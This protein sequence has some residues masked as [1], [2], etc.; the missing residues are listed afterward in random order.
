MFISDQIITA[1]FNNI[2]PIESDDGKAA[3]E[4]TSGIRYFLAVA[5]IL[6]QNDLEQIDVSPNNNDNRTAFIEAVGRVVKL[7][8]T[9]YTKNFHN[10][11]DNADD[12]RVRNNF[13][14][15]LRNKPYPR[16][17]A[18]LIIIQNDAVLSLHED[19]ETNLLRYGKWNDYK[20]SLAVWLIRFDN[21]PKKTVANHEKLIVAIH[22]KLKDRYGNKVADVL[23]DEA[24]LK[25]FISSFAVPLYKDAKPDYAQISLPITSEYGQNIILYGAPGTGKSYE[26]K[27]LR[28]QIRTV[29]HPDY[30]NSDFIGSY[31]PYVGDGKITYKFVPGPFIKVFVN[32]MLKPDTPYYLIIEEINRAN[33]S[34]VFGEVFQL[35]DRNTEGES[36]YRIVVD[37]SVNDFLKEKLSDKWQGELFIPANFSIYATMNSADQGVSY[38]DTAF[39]RRW[40]FRY[41]PIDFTTIDDDDIRNQKLIDYNGEKYSWRTLAVSINT[42]LT[43]E[44]IQEDRLLGQ[45]FLSNNDFNNIRDIANV[46][47]GKLFIYLW[48]DVLRH[49]MRNLIFNSNYT[50]FSTLIHAYRKGKDIFSDELNKTLQRLNDEE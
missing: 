17:P 3:K 18:P 19:F 10:E 42:I 5:E 13:L 27:Q 32:A 23:I 47:S 2:T 11:T 31:R 33:A 12:Y 38:M 44:G 7:N 16:R 15:T 36:E 49:G 50:S 34:A 1:A 25:T 39:K 40:T 29:F 30:Q 28:P 22:A 14:T 9:L 24:E 37:D 6:K 43:Q 20:T 45:Y 4:R 35:L 48:D 26:L 8:E 46:I 21:F 41:L